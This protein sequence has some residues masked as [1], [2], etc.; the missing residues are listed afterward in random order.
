MTEFVDLRDKY[1]KE[2]EA[3]IQRVL[4]QR[5]DL[6]ALSEEQ[7]NANVTCYYGDPKHAFELPH[8]YVEI[9]K[10]LAA[11]NPEGPELPCFVTK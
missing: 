8:L 4:S 7:R 6:R 5:P 2:G 10:H 9:M 1:E 3:A 11:E